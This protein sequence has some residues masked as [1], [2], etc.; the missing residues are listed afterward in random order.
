MADP[1]RCQPCLQ[2]RVQHMHQRLQALS[3]IQEATLPIQQALS[4]LGTLAHGTQQEVHQRLCGST[5]GVEPLVLLVVRARVPVWEGSWAGQYRPREQALH[6][7]LL[8]GYVRAAAV[9]AA[10]Q[11]PSLAEGLEPI[12]EQ[13]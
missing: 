7:R 2:V 13:S 5:P 3:G 8:D 9:Q 6:A 12:M 10:Q 1:V 11:Q 4:Y